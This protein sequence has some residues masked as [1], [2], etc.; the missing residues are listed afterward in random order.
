MLRERITGEIPLW[1]SHGFPY[2][3]GVTEA[4]FVR[5]G[6]SPLQGYSRDISIH[7]HTVGGVL[8]EFCSDCPVS[9]RKRAQAEGTCIQPILQR[10]RTSMALNKADHVRAWEL[11]EVKHLTI[12]ETASQL[13]VSK[14]TVMRMLQRA[15]AEVRGAS[16]A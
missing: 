9:Q 4:E 5:W 10:Y 16:G 7:S 3:C 12:S 2:S 6:F 11:V 14:R 15:R 1:G 8:A 13:G